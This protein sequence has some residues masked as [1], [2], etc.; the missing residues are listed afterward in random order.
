MLKTIFAIIALVATIAVTGCSGGYK[1]PAHYNPAYT[2]Y[3]K[4]SYP[5]LTI[6]DKLIT[7]GKSTI[8]DVRRIYGTPNYIAET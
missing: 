8:D 1:T 2:S 3:L 6:T 7:K 5:D 4:G